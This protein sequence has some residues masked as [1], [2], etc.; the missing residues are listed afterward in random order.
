MKRKV[1]LG[2]MGAALS[3]S[4]LDANATDVTVYVRQ[5]NGTPIPGAT[6][7]YQ[8][9]SGGITT[10]GTTD[11]SGSFTKTGISA[12][13]NKFYI[14]YNQSSTSGTFVVTNG[15]TTVTFY[16]TAVTLNN[17]SSN[18]AL[19]TGVSSR[20]TW[21][22]STTNPIGDNV[23]GTGTKEIFPGTYSMT[24]SYKGTGYTRNETVA[25]DGF[26]SNVATTLSTY[27]SALIL[28][29][30]SNGNVGVP[31]V[32]F[33]YT[34]NGSTTNQAGNT[35]ANG[36]KTMELFP[37]TYT[38]NGGSI[39][40]TTQTWTIAIGGDGA[41]AGASQNEDV[42]LSRVL[43]NNIG[44]V[45]YDLNGIK[46][47]TGAA[48]YMFPGDYTLRFYLPG[49]NV[50]YY[51]RTVSISGANYEKAAA[52]I[53]L[54]DH[55]GNLGTIN[56]IRGGNGSTI[57][58]HVSAV[59]GGNHVSNESA[60]V[61][62][63]I[64]SNN[65]NTSRIYEVKRNGTISTQTQDLLTSNVFNFQTNA[66]TLRLQKCN[67][68]GLYGGTIRWG[69]TNDNAASP[70]IGNHWSSAY[71]FDVSNNGTDSNGNT[72]M[73]VFPG[74]FIFEMNY[75]SSQETKTD[76]PVTGNTTVTWQTTNVKIN[77]KGTGSS[78]AYGV[79]S[80]NTWWTYPA[81]GQ[82]LLP[83]TLKFNFI[84]NGNNIVDVTIPAQCT[85]EKTVAIVRL[86]SS[87]NA[88]LSGGE[89]SY[90]LSSW[91]NAASPTGAN[92]STV[93]LLNGNPTTLNAV[94]MSY[95]GTRQQKNTVN[96][97][98]VNNV[99]LF[100]TSLITMSLVGSNNNPIEADANSLQYYAGG[101]K[102]FGTGS[103]TNGIATM[104]LLAGTTYSYAMTLGGTREQKSNWNTITTPVIPFQATLITMS[105][106]DANNNPIEADANSLQ[107]Y[108]GGWKTF[109]TGSTT[110]GIATMDLLAGTGNSFAMTLG[111]TREQKSNWNTISNPV[112]PF[113]ATLVTMSLVDA[114]DNA[115]EADA[116]S[117]QYYAGGWKTFG[118]GSTTNGTASM[119]LLGGTNT[120]FAMNLNGSRQQKSNWNTISDPTVP[121][122]STKVHI[123]YIGADCNPASGAAASY[124]ANGWKSLGSTDA[125]G[126][127]NEIDLL[128][129]SSYTFK[130]GS[131]PQRSGVAIDAGPVQSVDFTQC[132]N[133]Q[134]RM[135]A[136]NNN[137]NS[138]N[139]AATEV[140]LYPNPATTE[141]NIELTGDNSTVSIYTMDGKLLHHQT[142]NAGVSTINIATFAHGIYVIKVQNG[143][144]VQTSRFE[145]Q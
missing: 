114:Y 28:K 88:P 125:N 66:L 141:L 93:L 142:Y 15:D 51:S 29:A 39:N 103:T 84:D 85:F 20:Y 60:G 119:N 40:G 5:S 112:V 132:T 64:S 3:L 143:N 74:K 38:F 12:G 16:T 101:W 24:S 65:A 121:F 72:S 14:E 126:N 33:R 69:Y 91:N 75:A 133:A 140:K 42:L 83:G 117:L 68:D 8:K 77:Y 107:Y 134:E 43:F 4:V 54:K 50:N 36:I 17:Y 118:T 139:A 21:G 135:G 34:A 7:K 49:S 53:I 137:G 98:A 94:A 124:Y 18:G 89:A 41:T 130:V 56:S 31:N 80:A 58:W 44:A 57:G 13:G 86:V 63:D 96:L 52:I 26:T 145:K 71:G 82:E 127:S 10:V 123:N 1:L 115:I 45:K 129:G 73:E 97:A 61:W 22:G 78:L 110:N 76:V 104:E 100:Q 108:A 81:N 90:Y 144:N 25:G 19:L 27:T 70:V 106:V 32:Q 128:P 46:T 131:L 138:N 99:I 23:T 109:G 2:L 47:I 67:G 37:G 62:I 35:D 120:S 136:N 79:G 9:N 105:L 59:N 87:T 102:T 6:I 48:Y 122:K 95:L 111:G 11:G 55:N 116:N 30:Y 113:Q 92:G